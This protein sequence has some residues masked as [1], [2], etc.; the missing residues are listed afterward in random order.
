MSDLCCKDVS[1]RINPS[2]FID[3][4]TEDPIWVSG[5]TDIN[6]PAF[7][8]AS[9]YL[10]TIRLNA[11]NTETIF[12]KYDEAS[13]SMVDKASVLEYIRSG[14]V[15]H[16]AEFRFVCA[17]A[18]II[19]TFDPATELT[20]IPTLVTDP[21]GL[22][23]LDAIK[24]LYVPAKSKT[25]GQF[26]V[27][28]DWWMG[29]IDLTAGTLT[30]LGMLSTFWSNMTYSPITDALYGTTFG[31]SLKKFSLLSNSETTV[32]AVV[33]DDCGWDTDR[34][35]LVCFGT[36]ITE[37]DTV[38]EI[39]TVT[40]NHTWVYNTSKHP[41]YCSSIHKFYVTGFNSDST[42]K[43]VYSYDT[44]DQ[45]VQDVWH[46]TADEPVGYYGV[47]PIDD[48]TMFAAI[49][50]ID[51]P[52]TDGF[53]KLCASGLLEP[54]LY[55]KADNDASGV[56]DT[57]S[58]FEERNQ[59]QVLE[60]NSGATGSIATVEGI[61]DNA[62]Q[63]NSNNLWFNQNLV[64]SLDPIWTN[65]IWNADFT[66]R[67]WVNVNVATPDSDNLLVGMTNCDLKYNLVGGSALTFKWR[68][69]PDALPSYTAIAAA[70]LAFGWHRVIFW[71]KKGIEIGLK[72]D[73]DAAVTVAAPVL[74]ALEFPNISIRSS[75]ENPAVDEFGIYKGLVLTPAEMLAD[76]NDG[77][78]TTWPEPTPP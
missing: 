61:I 49:Y 31:N 74:R 62:W 12:S 1:I 17:S 36:V 33:A 29:E 73:N 32:A 69:K 6:P 3:C 10:L 26:Q 35:L 45:R 5:H 27:A 75:V 50:D 41:V 66:I 37:V 9:G 15:Y 57:V 8:S 21:I 58:P 4:S 40:N 2:G 23:T 39:A 63:L 54:Y 18:G 51:N 52:G 19:Y 25:Y 20:N 55:F 43:I 16:A 44:E 67:L 46:Q 59:M 47:F 11:A 48:T 14:L 53:R 34:D 72:I 38:T 71:Y 28:G 68:W 70:A 24:F 30:M 56:G 64:G 60:S 42:E 65:N 77:D 78:G 76:W 22:V 13:N 7:A